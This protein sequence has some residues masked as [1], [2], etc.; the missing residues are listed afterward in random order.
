MPNGIVIQEPETHGNEVLADQD[1]PQFMDPAL[2]HGQV[3][4]AEPVFV[5]NSAVNNGLLDDKKKKKDEK[6]RLKNKEKL[7]HR[8]K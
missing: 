4:H 1:R 3:Y 5:L 6:K 7:A 8:A 2:M